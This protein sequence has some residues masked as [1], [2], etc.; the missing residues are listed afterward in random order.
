M[1]RRIKI[2][3]LLLVKLIGEISALGMES[4]DWCGFQL[5]PVIGKEKKPPGKT[6]LSGNSYEF[7]T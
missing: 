6:W 7:V 2:T 3:P 5:M 1:E 4:M